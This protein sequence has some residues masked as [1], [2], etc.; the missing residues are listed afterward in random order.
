LLPRLPS[1][2]YYRG[3]WHPSAITGCG[4]LSSSSQVTRYLAVKSANLG[5][6]YRVRA[7]YV[8]SSKD[9]SNLNTDSGWH[10]FIV[11]K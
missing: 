8:R 4:I 7:D 11:E 2:E 3:A 5:Y 6:H 10:Y 9:I 1:R